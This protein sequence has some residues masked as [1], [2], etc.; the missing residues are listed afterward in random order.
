MSSTYHGMVINYVIHT[1]PIY[2]FHEKHFCEVINTM[3]TFIKASE[4]INSQN[5]VSHNYY[6]HNLYFTGTSRRQSRKQE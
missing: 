3:A 5:L 4:Y 1:L 2:E 6:N